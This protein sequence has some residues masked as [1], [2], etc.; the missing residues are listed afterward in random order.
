[1]NPLFTGPLSFRAKLVLLF[2]GLFLLTGAAVTLAVDR[3]VSAQVM[4]SN[5]DELHGLARTISKAIATNLEE[6][7]REVALLAAS[8]TFTGAALDSKE[9][10]ENLQRVKKTYRH[11]AWIGV[12]RPDGIVASAA[13][14]V[15]EGKSVA[16]RPWFIEGS[17]GVFVGDIHEAVLL[18]KLLNPPANADPLRFVDFASPIYD[19]SGKFSGVLATHALW[20]WVDEIIANLLPQNAGATGVQVFIA[21][22]HN[23]L[24]S[25]YE[26]VGKLQLPA[27]TSGAEKYRID[28][29]PDG[30]KYLF[31]D[32]RIDARTTTDLG[33]HVVVRQPLELARLPLTRLRLVLAV[34]SAVASALFLVVAYW[35]ARGVSQP[36][37]AIA[38]SAQRIAEGD[39][40]EALA[41][42]TA[43]RELE[44][45]SDALIAMT[46]TLTRR[47]DELSQINASLEHTIAERTAQLQG[48]KDLA[49]QASSAKSRF[50]A[51]VSHE[52]RTPMNGVLGM[53]ELASQTALDSRQREYVEKAEGAARSLLSLLNDILDFSK[54]EAGQLQIDLHTFALEDLMQNLA[55]VLGGAHTKPGVKLIFDIANGI[56]PMLVG[57]RM[58]IQQVLIN[59]G[60]NALK[61]TE[62]GQVIVTVEKL[63]QKDRSARLRFSVSDTGIGITDEQRSR[64]FQS[65]VQAEASTS[66]RFGGTGLGLAISRHL[67]HLM[68]GELAV[69]SE[70]GKGSRFYFD[71]DLGVDE[72]AGQVSAAI[73]NTASKP[74]RLIVIEP[75]PV[76]AQTLCNYAAMAQWSCESMPDPG[77]AID[78]IRLSN[79]SGSE[80][81]AVLVDGTLPDQRATRFIEAL[82]DAGLKPAPVVLLLTPA[83][84]SGAQAPETKRGI[85]VIHLGTPLTPRKMREAIQSAVYGSDTIAQPARAAKAKR[86]TGLNILL[87]EDNALNRHLA[88]EL[89][90]NEGAQVSVAE[91]GQ[92]GADMAL[93][94]AA[95]L[96]VILMDMQMPV[97]DG[98][99]ATRRIRAN[100]ATSALPIVAMTANA[101]SEDR[102][103]CIEAG[104][105]DYVGKPFHIDELVQT[106][107][108]QTRKVAPPAAANT[109]E[110]TSALLEPWDSVLDRFGG[111]VTIYRK[112]FAGL[113]HA[114]DQQMDLFRA[115]LQEANAVQAAAALHTLRGIASTA[116]AQAL[117]H[118]ALELESVLKGRQDLGGLPNDPAFIIAKLKALS[119]DSLRA[120]DARNREHRIDQSA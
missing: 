19:K 46:S 77:A 11:Y 2:G 109:G 30:S 58:R 39:E 95:E 31:T 24:L 79:A 21:D 8:P 18:S 71:L 13:D 23:A 76:M 85:K 110:P 103:A 7:E 52:I 42:V 98:L 70:S 26:F 93:R 74:L 50:V 57:D 117:A 96:D 25:P 40:H 113:A 33:W 68:G 115:G 94:H 47:K 49:E 22:R 32:V 75:N 44:K 29:W 43:S 12:A 53:L 56:P 20:S 100:E 4:Q 51:N 86:L 108:R 41:K 36:I 72:G 62:N 38:R 16:M 101:T 89:L 69:Q 64:I 78:A 9:V 106:L 102:E 91:D 82:A 48:A 114:L 104:M 81:T 88:Q 6:R 28:A 45:L 59:L 87:V 111:H 112:I 66:R 61:F 116:G 14:G 120:L 97:V 84:W 5:G 73:G 118:Y 83:S 99:E 105:N 3:I 55:V 27:S 10:R 1:M 17:K 37:E 63:M 67:V 60:G 107:L 90:A 80:I 15:L 65:F 54:I 34:L 35:V 119:Q 92:I